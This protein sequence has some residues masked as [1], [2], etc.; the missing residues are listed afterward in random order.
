VRITD[1]LGDLPFGQFHRLFALAF[2]IFKFCIFGRYGTASRNHSV[3]RLLLLSITDL[4]FSFR[5]WHTGI[6]GEAK[7]V[8]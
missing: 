5:A 8:W 6:L 2:S 4:I 1:P 3:T 7:A